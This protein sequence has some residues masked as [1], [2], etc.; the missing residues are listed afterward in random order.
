[1]PHIKTIV[2][3]SAR[4][5]GTKIPSPPYKHDLF[6]D[7][8]TVP[9]KKKKGKEVN[10]GKTLNVKK[11]KT[12]QPLSD[13]DSFSEEEVDNEVNA[14]HP[15]KNYSKID[16]YDRW[17][18]SRN[19]ATDN[20]KQLV[21]VQKECRREQKEVEKLKKELNEKFEYVKELQEVNSELKDQVKELKSHSTSS[22]KKYNGW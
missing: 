19:E 12:L 16:L 4:N 5:A 15:S 8:P 13:T 7:P 6:K 9:S 14:S 3:R 11:R 18:K 22:K 20:K 10:S 2:R 21:E 1:M 17:V